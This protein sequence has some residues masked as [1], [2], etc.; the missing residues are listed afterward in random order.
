[1]K[2][3][4]TDSSFCHIAVVGFGTESKVTVFE[5]VNCKCTAAHLKYCRCPLQTMGRGLSSG[6]YQTITSMD[7]SLII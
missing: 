7:P 4:Y 6:W 2:E 3:I 1:M 5:Q